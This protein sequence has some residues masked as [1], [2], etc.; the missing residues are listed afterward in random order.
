MGIVELMKEREANRLI[1]K[2]AEQ[3]S[4]EFIKKLLAAKRF[5]IAEIADFAGVTEAFVKKIK[6]GKN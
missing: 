2:V 4:Y 6:A 3:K 5:S 1:E